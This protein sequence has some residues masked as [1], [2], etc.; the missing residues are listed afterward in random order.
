MCVC[1]VP[2]EWEMQHFPWGAS[3]GWYPEVLWKDVTEQIFHTLGIVIMHDV[4]LCALARSCPYHKGSLSQ[5][6]SR[7]SYWVVP[8]ASEL[9][10]RRASGPK[11]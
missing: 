3:L 6:S 9:K 4:C 8:A 7:I 10:S 11:Q 1:A 5:T 2:N